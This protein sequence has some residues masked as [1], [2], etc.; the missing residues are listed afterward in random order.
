MANFMGVCSLCNGNVTVPDNWY[1]NIPPA[2]VCNSCGATA[3]N[4]FPV[5]EMEK[6]DFTNRNENVV[7][8]PERPMLLNE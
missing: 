5:V 8:F 3:K 2:P 7:P 4:K 1:S 6:R